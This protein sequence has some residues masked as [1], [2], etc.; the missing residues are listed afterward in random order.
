MIQ[1]AY[2]IGFVLF[3]PFTLLPILVTGFWLPWLISLMILYP[4]LDGAFSVEK[5]IN[6]RRE[7]E[8]QASMEEGSLF[9]SGKND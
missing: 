8:L 4:A 3:L 2:W 9:G 7:E 6:R 5:E 1:S